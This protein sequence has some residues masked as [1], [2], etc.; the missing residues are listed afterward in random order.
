MN[1]Q[2]I[3]PYKE[4]HLLNSGVIGTCTNPHGPMYKMLSACVVELSSGV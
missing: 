4:E 2:I 3:T 1:T